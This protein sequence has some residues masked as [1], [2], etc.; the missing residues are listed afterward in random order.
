MVYC[1]EFKALYV[2]DYTEGPK[3]SIRTSTYKISA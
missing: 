3:K 1:N 2:T